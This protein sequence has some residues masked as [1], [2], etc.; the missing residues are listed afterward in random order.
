MW[1]PK[2]CVLYFYFYVRNKKKTQKHTMKQ[3]KNKP[4][5]PFWRRFCLCFRCEWWAESNGP[6]VTTNTSTSCHHIHPSELRVS[7]AVTREKFPGKWCFSALHL[8]LTGKAE[9]GGSKSPAWCCPGRGT[10]S[11]ESWR[12]RHNSE[13]S[14]LSPSPRLICSADTSLG[15][16]ERNGSQKMFWWRE[17]VC[18]CPHHPVGCKRKVWAVPRVTTLPCSFPQIPPVLPYSAA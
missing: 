12:H 5:N 10:S 3:K 8:N 1:T 7:G 18:V 17:C 4:H 16:K 6:A 11:P 9:E 2:I 15:E 14:F 13:Q